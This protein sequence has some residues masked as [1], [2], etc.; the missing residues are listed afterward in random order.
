M[1]SHLAFVI[2]MICPA[3]V[4]AQDVDFEQPDS[5][6]GEAEEISGTEPVTVT[7][8]ARLPM[9]AF[10]T[11]RS[12]N[13]VT[14]ETI[15]RR[16]AKS[17]TEA[18]EEEPGIHVQSTNRGAGTLMLR[19]LTGPEN[20]IY[21]DGV[22]FN[23]STFRTGPNQY[24][25]TIDP[26]ALRRIE[27]VRGPGSVLYGT[28]A[29]GGVVQMFP[30][31]LP[32]ETVADSRV[33]YESADNTAG[34]NLEG[35]TA[36]G[37]FSGRV[38]GTLRR[39]GRLRIG[40]TGGQD[41]FVSGADGQ[42]FLAQPYDE[43]YLRGGA[44]YEIG[45]HRFRLNYFGGLI[46]DAMRVDRVGDGEVRIYDNQDHLAYGTY[47]VDGPP[48]IDDLR[49]NVS[50]HRTVEDVERFNCAQVPISVA[51][52]D[53]P[54]ERVVDAREC[55]QLED[56][57]IEKKRHNFDRVDTVG[58]SVTGVTRL[59]DERLSITWG[60]DGYSDSVISERE[61][62]SAPGF[63]FE[64]RD[65][66]N[67]ASNSTYT[68]FGLFALGRFDIW[69]WG[70]NVLRA[71][72]GARVENFAAHAPG[73]TEELGT[74]RYNFTGVAGSAGLAYV[75][76]TQLNA[77]LNWNEGF[78]APNLQETTVLGDSGNFYEVPNPDLGPERS[79]TFEL[80]T[81]VDWVDA[82]RLH[83][84]LWVSLL[85]NR[86]TRAPTTFEGQSEIDGKQ[87]RQRINRDSAYF[88]GFDLGAETQQ[89]SGL[90]F[91]GNFS[92]IDGAVAVDE[93]DPTFEAG[94]LHDV[95]SSSEFYQNPR[96]LPPLQYLFGVRYE[97]EDSWYVGFF[98]QGNG[99]Q[100][101]LA[102]DDRDDQRIC[103]ERLGAFYSELGEECPGSPGWLT[104]NARAGY[105][106]QGMMLDVAA[107]NLTDERYRRHG[108]GVPAPGFNLQAQLT[109]NY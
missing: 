46:G 47:E 33:A 68:T 96:R 10:D 26:W 75:S 28:G 88:Y 39:H 48:A 95:L 87:V 60:G 15:R 90:A 106:Y 42:E 101:K 93:E 74:V 8:S 84:A 36:I 97:P 109:L 53:E 50:F 13:V 82:I 51:G 71:Q 91:Y 105:R 5:T 56:A 69:S 104:F 62:A 85:S 99:A 7:T 30:H 83:P 73:V 16:Q 35:G 49:V 67:F 92:W 24:L 32:E 21:F 94:P 64:P 22:R 41:I 29:M 70:P 81:K 63:E 76:G 52:V 20:M 89:W 77:Y 2:T 98:L 14:D 102:P 34:V 4:L 6:T 45:D 58:S 25:N 3:V 31:Q 103:E 38:G 18:V 65:R 72:G 86:I 79:D 59:L 12:E 27:V 43:G 19:G 80:G 1:K 44:G 78:R 61:D 11:E 55:A 108:S 40:S 57:I 23:Q 107:K 37:D 66:G 9:P 54:Y 17:I 100:T